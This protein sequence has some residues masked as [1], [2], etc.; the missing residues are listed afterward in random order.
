MRSG[1]P[2]FLAPRAGSKLRAGLR[3]L[4]AARVLHGRARLSQARSADAG[5]IQGAGG[6]EKGLAARRRRSR[7]VVVGLPRPRAQQPAAAGRGQQ[8]DRGRGAR[9]RRAGAGAD[10]RNR[11]RA[12]FPLVSA[13]YS[14]TALGRGP[15]SI[16]RRPRDRHHQLLSARNGVLDP[17]R[18]GQDPP[19][20]RE[21]CRADAQADAGLLA[22]A[23]LSAQAQLAIAYFNLRAEDLL[24]RPAPAHGQDLPG[25][26]E[27]HAEP[28]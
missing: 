2:S 11:R 18:L 22:N 10:P 16:R 15:G 25:N 14:V 6:L 9:R 3:R 20:G 17:R 8:P 5:Q 26:A 12:C 13:N 27:D 4:A 28:V 1:I 21:Q 24:T 23:K 19:A 7:R